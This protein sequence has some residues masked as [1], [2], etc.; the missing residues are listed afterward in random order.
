MKRKF[1]ARQNKY[2][3]IYNE[4]ANKINNVKVFAP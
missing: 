2:S 3:D 4:E 1:V